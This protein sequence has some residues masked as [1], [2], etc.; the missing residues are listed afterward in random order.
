MLETRAHSHSSEAPTSL[1]VRVAELWADFTK[2]YAIYPASNV[3]V[4]K[5]LERLIAACGEEGAYAPA[6]EGGTGGLIVLFREGAFLA[7]GVEGE[8]APGT[9]LAWLKERLDVGA[10]AGV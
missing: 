8:I 10:L 6:S 2:A 5:C 3:R 1:G 4:T 7:A 9:N